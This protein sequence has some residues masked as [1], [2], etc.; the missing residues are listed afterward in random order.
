MAYSTIYWLSRVNKLVGCNLVYSGALMC[1][2]RA[3]WP[4][5]WCW[6]CVGNNWGGVFNP[7]S[8]VGMTQSMP[9]CDIRKLEGLFVKYSKI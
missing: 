8:L 5:Y 9:S 7:L 3:R 1:L 2:V 4:I 6:T